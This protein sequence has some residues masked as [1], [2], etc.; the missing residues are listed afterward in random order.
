MNNPESERSQ[1]ASNTDKTMVLL[2]L[3]A[4]TGDEIGMINWFAVH[5]TSVGN[6][7]RLITGDNKGYAEYRFEKLKGTDYSAENQKTFVAS[8]AQTNTGDV[9]P[10]IYWG[11]PDGVNDYARMKIIGDRQYEK[12]L[13]L[14][15]GAG[16]KLAGAWITAT[17]M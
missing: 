8:F 14:Y 7:N 13:A 12:A 3:L 6:T 4:D 17:A 5:P 15:N 9:S 16:E 1:Y 11:Y 10:N 2:K